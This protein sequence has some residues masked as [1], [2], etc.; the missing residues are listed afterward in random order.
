MVVS[1]T[2]FTGEIKMKYMKGYLFS[3][4]DPNQQ[5]KSK[6]DQLMDL[7]LQLLTYTSGDVNEALQWL[8]ELD[9][10]YKFTGEEYGMG[11]FIDDLKDKGYIDENK[12]TGEINITPKTEQGIRKRS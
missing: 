7:F 1:R 4:Y 11:D 10:E 3:K 12:Q 2:R 8:N 9:K 6:F 5:S